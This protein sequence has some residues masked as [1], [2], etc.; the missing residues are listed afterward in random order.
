MILALCVAASTLVFL[1]MFGIAASEGITEVS[2]GALVRQFDIGS[3]SAYMLALLPV[4]ALGTVVTML[5]D[6]TISSLMTGIFAT[7]GLVMAI[8]SVA[9]LEIFKTFDLWLLVGFPALLVPICLSMSYTVFLHGESL[10]TSKKFW[11]LLPSFFRP[12]FVI[13]AALLISLIWILR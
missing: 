3:V 10:R 4:F 13:G 2:F 1:A 12:I 11:V 9:N 5:V 6:R 7:L 8:A